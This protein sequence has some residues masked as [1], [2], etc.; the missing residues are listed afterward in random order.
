MA[1]QLVPCSLSEPCYQDGCGACY[2]D[3]VM[4]QETEREA[5]AMGQLAPLLD[6]RERTPDVAKG[7][8]LEADRAAGYAFRKGDYSRALTWLESARQLASDLPD[9]DEHF[10]RV[11]AAQREA[12]AEVAKPRD[13]GEAADTFGERTQ[14]WVAQRD[15]NR[16]EP[17]EPCDA[18]KGDK[19]C[20]ELG[21]LYPAGRRCD[22][23]RPKVLPDNELGQ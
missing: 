7:A 5:R 22:L 23:H 17:T 1:A 15:A 18:P 6:P 2:P 13:L 16:G 8:A 19:H 4:Q 14:Q 9:L 12:A 3:K 21:H 10:A 20:G 11:R